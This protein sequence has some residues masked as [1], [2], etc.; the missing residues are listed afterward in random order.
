[1]PQIIN[2]N[3][4]SLNA[5]RNLNK[6]QAANQTALQRL[7][8]GLRIN[9]A[10][11][12]AAG[13]AISTR[14]N[15]QI[16]GLNVAVRNAGDGI[17][18]AQTAEGALGTMNDNLQRIRELAVQSANATNSD[19]DRDAL[20]AEVSQLLAEV[21][22]T[23]EETD[24]NGRK[25]LD[26]TFAA[27]FQ[28]GANAGQT[29]E[30][31]IAELT[32]DKLGS[33]ST[34]GISANGNANALSNGDLIINTIAIA[35][36]K[37]GDDTSSTN[38]AGAS[39]IA[40]VAAINRHTDETGVTASVNDNVVSGAEMQGAP[41]SGT[42]TLNGVSISLTTTTSTSGT[43][44]S[45]AE[46]IN[47]V[48]DQTG[49]IAINSE[50][51][52]GGVQLVAEDGRN[53]QIGFTTITSASTGI[54]ATGTYEGGFTLVADAAVGSIEIEGGNGTGKGDLANA[55]LVAGTYDRGVASNV[56]DVKRD[57]TT[58]TDFSAVNGSLT[59][60]QAQT[61][62]TATILGVGSNRTNLVLGSAGSAATV[63]QASAIS[64][65][66]S[67][68]GGVISNITISEGTDLNSAI[69]QLDA[70]A[71]VNAY[72]RIVF[73]VDD[74][75][76][77]TGGNQL[78]LAGQ[79][80]AMP[81]ISGADFA[82]TAG[83]LEYLTG[84]INDASYAAGITVSAELNFAQTQISVVI[85]NDGG[86][87]AGNITFA[88]TT[89]ANG[90]G[91]I[92][93]NFVSAGGAGANFTGTI[94]FD[95]VAATSATTVLGVL[96]F[97]AT[98]G[99]PITIVASE[100]TA[101]TALSQNMFSGNTVE[102]TSYGLQNLA[103]S[104]KSV[105]AVT[106]D[107]VASASTTVDE[108]A[109]VAELAAT[110][111]GAYADVNAWE[112]ISI[113]FSAANLAVGDTLYIGTGTGGAVSSGAAVAITDADG[114]GA[115]TISDIA[116]NING[117]DF[118]GQNM[119]I[120]VTLNAAGT[121]FTMEIRN[122]SG[123]E[124]QAVTDAEGRTLVVTGGDL[125]GAVEQ[126][127]SGSLA[128]A[129][130][131]AQTIDLSIS[132]PL[133]GGNFFSGA[134]VSTNYTSVNG[135]ADGDLLINDVSIG[136]A[137]TGLDRATAEF[138][139]DAT[140]ILSSSKELSAISVAGAI[141]KVSSETGVSATINA[142]KVV[143]GDGTA[144]T[145]AS[146][147]SGEFNIGDTSE[148]F[149]NGY[150]AGVITLQDNGSGSI[151]TDR[152]K[153]D[154]LSLINGVS[155]KTGVVAEDNGVSLTL[156]ADDGRNISIAIDDQ[157]GANASIGAMFGLDA[158]NVDGI[159]ESTFGD[160]PSSSNNGISAESA[161]YQTTYGTITLESAGEFTIAAGGEGADELTALGLVEGSYGGASDGQFLTEIDIS[162]FEGATAA[163][164]AIDNA[165]GAIA[166]QR[167]V[168][169]AI[170]NRMES[171]VN[172]LAITSENLAAANSRIQDADFAAETAELS[173]TQV[174]QQAG[175]SILAQA[176][177]G[178]QQVLSLLG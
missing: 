58:A 100:G 120:S 89:A 133:S 140:R 141:N 157:S 169:G 27:T 74:F 168:L 45:V 28:I 72:E 37:A 124:V 26:G 48:S 112:A 174:L 62:D 147:T 113:T 131:E 178:P 18:L 162:T 10:K 54:A 65:R 44:A 33:A 102:F 110:I 57:T 47:A 16:R 40:K 129:A 79:T 135:L 50:S 172:N 19:V 87:S 132:D 68:A 104:T 114:S 108:D 119:D 121:A 167:A 115:V 4:A 6:S 126:S 34:A 46:A 61:S 170:Q 153:S 125:V 35:A 134:S 127:L 66:V 25:L 3:I 69:G 67:S 146:P 32:A 80:I 154:A 75:S 82:T 43:R 98:A 96:A 103:S 13:L 117:T 105:V 60:T 99:V 36:S 156:V 1:M 11:D 73:V 95:V 145:G 111:N 85:D 137:E 101:A 166:G 161:T 142:T 107:G 93:G 9:S 77:V 24:F 23:A 53:I 38:N 122:F 177:Q 171:T 86:L 55:G 84:A 144:I 173:R 176:N 17:S 70:I 148:L 149:I 52:N 5:Q 143:G 91:T 155:G 56:N 128:Y 7:S 42:L 164:T 106:I 76:T 63:T 41:L 29:L 64:F 12:D 163:L 151:D 118:S 94:D 109:T 31:S 8:S 158:D 49:V 97:E 30:I 136:S 130:T 78:Y 175:I 150:S 15:S 88:M 160:S 71:G 138:A 22:R 165:I 2:T 59:N 81:D 20:Q 139:S 83:R 116:A 159:G 92:G 123:R 90:T 39:A 21:S 152:A 14:F 51:D